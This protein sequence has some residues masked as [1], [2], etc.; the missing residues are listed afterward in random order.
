MPASALQHRNS[1]GTH[2]NK[3]CS[4]FNRDPSQ[5]AGIN[6]GCS[7]IP[8]DIRRVGRSILQASN[9]PES[10]NRSL[11]Q[12]PVSQQNAVVPFLMLVTQLRLPN[13]PL[14]ATSENAV[15]MSERE[16][17]PAV[18]K[19]G[20]LPDNSGN[21]A[22]GMLGSLTTL[23]NEAGEMISRYDP[24]YFPGAD[25][26]PVKESQNKNM[27]QSTIKI[28]HGGRKSVSH[29]KKKEHSSVKAKEYPAA[30][31]RK[32]GTRC[33]VL[34]GGEGYQ[35]GINK[36]AVKYVTAENFAELKKH[37]NAGEKYIYIP[38]SVT[39]TI[40]NEKNSLR[41]KSGQV[42]FGSR[43]ING[44]EGGK[45]KVNYKDNSASSYAIILLENSSRISGLR[46]EGPGQPSSTKNLIVGLQTIPDGG[47][48]VI[49]NNEL[50]GWSAAAVSINKSVLNKVHHNYIHDNVRHER[51]Y[52]VTV[53]NGKADVNVYCNAFVKNRHAIAGKGSPG[54]KYF[55]YDNLIRSAKTRDEYHQFDMHKFNNT[56]GE[57]IVITNNIF[58]YGQFGT[59]NRASVRVRG[60]PEA[61]P[62][63]VK[64]NVFSQPFHLGKQNAVEQAD[65]IKKGIP[66]DKTIKKKNKFNVK[67]TYRF[68]KEGQCSVEF[69]NKESPVNCKA[70][71]LNY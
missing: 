61:G 53:Q 48:V 55:A 50:Y 8:R 43:G 40:P 65:D 4:T 42:I 29:S 35:Q 39:I 30:K 13:A 3:L 33:D 66:N 49:D 60:N 58:D 31:S 18:F 7:V 17:P 37:V 54:E 38:S 45:L 26:S 52:G 2:Q 25:A 21:S 71:G 11:C 68:D 46:I 59:S 24:L 5:A 22:S 6:S 28:R 56:G 23:L 34:G 32:K 41:V 44:E 27:P 10:Q 14:P 64:G 19:N 15:S 51:G 62:A 16:V 12:A 47:S 69:G 36:D 63:I 20:A 70:A 1:I 57:K 9:Y 67:M